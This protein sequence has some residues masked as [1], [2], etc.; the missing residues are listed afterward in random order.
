MNYATIEEAW[1]GDLS[2]R[3]KKKTKT[4]DPICELYAQSQ[5]D[6]VNNSNA[7]FEKSKHQRNMKP[8]AN[9]SETDRETF[10]KKIVI[11]EDKKY[12]DISDK[13]NHIS[14]SLF[15]KQFEIQHPKMY[16][17]DDDCSSDKE[18]EIIKQKVNKVYDEEEEDLEQYVYK[19]QLSP[20]P[21]KKV[22][23]Y[24]DYLEEFGYEQKKTKLV[25][26]DLLLYII[27]GIILI[28]LLNQ[29]VEIGK[30]MVL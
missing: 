4:Q 6:L 8:L 12:Y 14:S 9:S 22:Q 19:K 18:F 30:N 10:D 13:P 21:Q 7:Q 3:R 28:F 24:D 23:Y 17:E 29:F 11:D 15:E 26:L 5:V 27:S 20:R 25:Y 1:G 16:D 2:G